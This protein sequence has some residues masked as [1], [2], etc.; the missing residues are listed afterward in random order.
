LPGGEGGP[1]PRVPQCSRTLNIW[2][3]WQD[4]DLRRL[5]PAGASPPDPADLFTPDPS[6]MSP[7]CRL[8]GVLPRHGTSRRPMTHPDVALQRARGRS[9][10]ADFSVPAVRV[11]RREMAHRG[12]SPG[13][14]AHGASTAVNAGGGPSVGRDAPP[15]CGS[16]HTTGARSNAI[17]RPRLSGHGRGRFRTTDAQSE[18]FQLGRLSSSLTRPMRARPA[19]AGAA[20]PSSV[21]D[22]AEGRCRDSSL[23]R[24]HPLITRRR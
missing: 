2:S 19:R 6:P 18:I 12:A 16:S 5:L 22:D 17:L 7:R 21:V 13:A 20:W 1:G 4:L 10:P 9:S 14:T 8:V 23:V 15:W 11:E 3:R 24:R